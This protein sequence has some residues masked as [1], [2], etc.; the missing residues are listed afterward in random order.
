[1]ISSFKEQQPNI[2]I[3]K[4]IPVNPRVFFL[5]L[6]IPYQSFT[7]MLF[8]ISF[9]STHFRHVLLILK[10]VFFP[11]L[12]K[13]VSF[14]LVETPM[15]VW[16]YLTRNCF[17]CFSLNVPERRLV[18]LCLWLH[19]D[20]PAHPPPSL[21]L[22]V[23]CKVFSLTITSGYQ[24]AILNF[25]SQDHQQILKLMML[26][27]WLFLRNLPPSYD[28]LIRGTTT[29]GCKIRHSKLDEFLLLLPR[30]RQHDNKTNKKGNDLGLLCH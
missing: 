5:T 6:L 28:T 13:G 25:L 12:S 29:W 17:V 8:V 23:V 7:E 19:L 26:I 3:R 24:V 20:T 1:M 2:P 15:L 11:Q 9:L 22:T 4:H 21:S 10:W 18:F 30:P 27:L 16:D 14:P